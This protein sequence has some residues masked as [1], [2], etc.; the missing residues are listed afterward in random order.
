[1]R[2]PLRWRARRI[3]IALEDVDGFVERLA[4]ARGGGGERSP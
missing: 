4:A 1:V 2:A 3:V